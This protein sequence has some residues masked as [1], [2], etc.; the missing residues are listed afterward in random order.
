MFFSSSSLPCVYE[1]AVRVMMVCA[2][3][4]VARGRRKERE[5]GE[6]EREPSLR[7]E[8]SS[9]WPR[10]RCGVGTREESLH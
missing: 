4:N 9:D 2:C 1:Y 6:G 8:I 10:A 5:R 3:V 7:V